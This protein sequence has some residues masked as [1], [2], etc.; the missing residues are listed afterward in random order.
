MTANQHQT[1]ARCSRSTLLTY[2]E[3]C[4]GRDHIPAGETPISCPRSSLTATSGESTSFQLVRQLRN[5]WR[6]TACRRNGALSQLRHRVLRRRTPQ[7]GR[8][9]VQQRGATCWEACAGS[10]PQTQGTPGRQTWIRFSCAVKT[11]C[12]GNGSGAKSVHTESGPGSNTLNSVIFLMRS[13]SHIASR[14]RS[15]STRTVQFE[16]VHAPALPVLS[17]L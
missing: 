10:A 5:C 8:G 11:C 1:A 14:R 13:G 6:R 2:Y 16:P 4:S 9:S 7:A 12:L 17:A 15:V 3:N